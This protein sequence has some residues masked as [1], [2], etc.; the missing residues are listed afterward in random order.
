LA[1]FEVDVYETK[2]QPGGMVS[3]A[4]P[5]FR[6]TRDAFEKDIERIKKLGIKI[7]YNTK[8]T[9]EKF[10]QLK[11]ESNYV[12]LAVGAQLTRKFNIEGIKSK[13]VIDPLNFLFSVKNNDRIK[14]GQNIAIIGGGNTAMDAARTAYRLVGKE[15]KVTILYR[16][17]KKEMPADREEIKAALSEGILIHELTLP[18]KVNSSNKQVHSLTCVKMKLEASD[19][20][21]RPI[22]IEIPNSEFTIEFDTVIPAIGLDMEFDFI[23]SKLLQ[24]EPGI[25]ETKISNVFIGGDALRGASTAINAIGDGRKA[26][27]IILKKSRGAIHSQ[28]INYNQKFTARI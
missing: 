5:A 22:P 14:L 7:H 1:G 3:A 18:I 8:I 9:K 28:T 20:S 19:S 10:E 11:S 16:R 24:S 23:D 21:D 2:G 25:Y 6:L 4:I 26:A 17:T 27:D 12:Y 13:G 15:G